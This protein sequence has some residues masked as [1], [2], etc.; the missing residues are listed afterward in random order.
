M[1]HMEEEKKTKVDEAT[2]KKANRYFFTKVLVNFVLVIIGALF[3]ILFMR[4][5]QAQTAIAKQEET[6]K[7]ALEEAVMSLE[8]NEQDASDLALIFHDSNQDVLGD[9][10]RLFSSGLF[11]SLGDA[12][13]NERSAVFA[14]MVERSGVQYLFMMSQ[15]G[16]IVLSP[17]ASL[18]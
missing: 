13:N 18:Y 15:E 14:D 5:M 2:R 11:E 17:E 4:Q 6:S 3:I 1:E 16:K 12:D 7:L 10:N 9:M 8:K